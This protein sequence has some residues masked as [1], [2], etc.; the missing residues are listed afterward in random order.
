M[1]IR[2]A[3]TT[4]IAAAMLLW[5]PGAASAITIPP[6]LEF[7][8]L[9]TRDVD[10]DYDASER[11]FRVNTPASVSGSITTFSIETRTVDILNQNFSID[12]DINAATG[13]VRSNNLSGGDGLR[14]TGMILNVPLA[15]PGNQVLLRGQLV[16]VDAV[17]DVDNSFT[18]EIQLLW[19]LTG[20][21][22]AQYYPMEQAITVLSGTGIENGSGSAFSQDGGFFVDFAQLGVDGGTFGVFPLPGALPMLLTALGAL[23]FVG[24]RRRAR[25]AA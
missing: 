19:N 13:E 22:L 8:D 7:P 16:G 12:V 20:G 5:L 4:M 9:Q 14:V 25:A 2:L 10:V 24:Y 3:L 6:T 15:P 11:R 23:G 21:I 17:R 18:G 1:G